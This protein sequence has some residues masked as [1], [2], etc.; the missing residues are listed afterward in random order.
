MQTAFKTRGLV[1]PLGLVILVNRMLAGLPDDWDAVNV[2][3]RLGHV[4][5]PGQPMELTAI[6]RRGNASAPISFDVRRLKAPNVCASHLC[7]AARERFISN[8][9][10]EESPD[11]RSP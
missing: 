9:V 8:R 2:Y 6:F 7:D 1:I 10:A 4:V 11:G 3:P 5:V